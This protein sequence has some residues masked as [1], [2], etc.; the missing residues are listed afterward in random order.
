MI[1]FNYSAQYLHGWG[2][3]QHIDICNGTDTAATPGHAKAKATVLA[4]KAAAEML[5]N[6]HW[7]YA[8]NPPNFTAVP[9]GLWEQTDIN[10]YIK[11]GNHHI[12]RVNIPI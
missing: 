4:R 7:Q 6:L 8:L 10:K 2:F 9:A 12:V 5:D 3:M 1:T 11:E